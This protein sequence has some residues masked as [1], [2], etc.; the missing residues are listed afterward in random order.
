M[1]LSPFVSFQS[2]FVTYLLNFPRIKCRLISVFKLK[3]NVIR[4]GIYIFLSECAY[5]NSILD[6]NQEAGQTIDPS[7]ARKGRIKRV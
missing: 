2:R 7:S 4:N 5:L 1:S 3:W 6:K